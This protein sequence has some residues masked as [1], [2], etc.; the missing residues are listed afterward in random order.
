MRVLSNVLQEK[1]YRCVGGG[2]GV[3]RVGCGCTVKEER[4]WGASER[5]RKRERS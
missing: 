5:D 2:R 4:R 1:I 3:V